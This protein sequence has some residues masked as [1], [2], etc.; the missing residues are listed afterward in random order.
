M[1]C[2]EVMQT[3]PHHK[4]VY[5]NLRSDQARYTST[6]ACGTTADSTR[7]CTARSKGGA[8]QSAAAAHQPT[9]AET[10][11]NVTKK[12]PTVLPQW[13]DLLPN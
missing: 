7:C 11:P 8:A 13:V 9:T 10:K 12:K 6:A 4:Y 2:R 1:T 5:A 3:M